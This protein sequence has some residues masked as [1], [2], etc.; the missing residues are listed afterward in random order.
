MSS[1]LWWGLWRDLFPRGKDDNHM[2]F[3][4]SSCYPWLVYDSHGCHQCFF[5]WWSPRDC[6]YEVSSWI[7]SIWKKNFS[8]LASGSLSYH[9]F[10]W[11]LIL[12]NQ[13]RTTV[14]SLK[15]LKQISQWCLYML[16]ICPFVATMRLWLLI[17]K[18]C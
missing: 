8:H 5:A 10:S 1:N 18:R 4:S 17:S 2:N 16:M 12:Y 13:S 15:E 11:S 3:S 14:C 6:L 9:Q 7:Y